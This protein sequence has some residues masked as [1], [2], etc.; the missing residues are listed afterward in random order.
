M[1]RSA[2]RITLLLS[3]AFAIV[4]VAAVLWYTRR[5]SV[6][7]Y[8][9]AET[10]RRPA[11]DSAPRDIMWEPAEPL[12]P[13]INTLDHEYEPRICEHGAAMFFVRG[14]AGE[15]A[16]IYYCL[17]TSAGWGEPAAL[18]AINTDA[19]ELGPEPSPDGLTLYFYSDRD[20]GAGGY[21]LWVTRNEDGVWREPVNLGPHVN[22]SF[23]EY[24][25]ALTPDESQ[26]YFSSNRPQPADAAPPDPDAWPATVR[27][28]LYQ[29]D[30]DLY[31]S[32]LTDRGVGNA[33]LVAGLNSEFNEGSPAISPVG[34]F[35]Y[36][37]SDRPGGEGGFDIYRSRRL[38]G[39]HLEAENLGPS[40]NTAANEL[41]PAVG[42]GGFELHFSSDRLREDDVAEI[43]G[44]YDLYSARSREVFMEYET[45]RAKIDW[46]ALAPY[47]PWALLAL[48]LLLLLLL[49]RRLELASRFATLS[50]LARCLL[51]SVLLHALAMMLFG[52]WTVSSALSDW[53][54]RGGGVRVA[55]VSPSVGDDLSVQVRGGLSE[56]EVEPV[57]ETVAQTA[58]IPAPEPIETQRRDLELEPTWIETEDLPSRIEHTADAPEP[59][60][61]Q[62]WTPSIVEAEPVSE[63]APMNLKLPE[64][65]LAQAEP[66]TQLQAQIATQEMT[67]ERAAESPQ[68]MQIRPADV[69][70]L[71]M[72]VDD[73]IDPAAAASMVEQVLPEDAPAPEHASPGLLSTATSPE[74]TATPAPNAPDLPLMPEAPTERV[75]ETEHMVRAAPSQHSKIQT[76]DLGAREPAVEPLVHIAPARRTDS[77]VAESMA[78][79][80][81]AATDAPV[82]AEGFVG[83]S[84]DHQIADPGMIALSLDA[85]PESRVNDD[86]ERQATIDVLTEAPSRRAL[87][88]PV[89]AR[90]PVDPAINTTV[91]TAQLI[92]EEV[93]VIELSITESETAAKAEAR[94]VN[95]P[96]GI[97]EPMPVELALPSMSEE[98]T[99]VVAE[100]AQDSEVREMAA[101]ERATAVNPS[102]PVAPT[103]RMDPS[104]EPVNAL[105]PLN[106]VVPLIETEAVDADVE[107]A[108]QDTGFEPLPAV[109]TPHPLDLALPTLEEDQTEAVVETADD[110]EVRDARR[111]ERVSVENPMAPDVPMRMVDPAPRRIDET[112]GV[113][114][115][116]PLIPIDLPETSS[117]PIEFEETPAELALLP[118]E[119]DLELPSQVEPPPEEEE[120]PAEIAGLIRGSVR[121]AV[122]GG[123]LAGATVRLDLADS[124]PVLATTDEQGNYALSAPDVPDFVALSASLE[125][126]TPQT[127]NVSAEELARQIVRRDFVLT[128]ERSNLIAIEADPRVHHLGD[129][130]FDGRINSQ[131]QKRSEGRRYR[132]EFEVTEAQLALAEGDAVLTLMAKGTQRD[133]QVRINGRRLE[134]SLNDSPSDGSFGEYESSFPVLRLNAGTNTIEVRSAWADRGRTDLDDFEF[135]NIQIELP[136]P[137]VAASDPYPQRADE[138]RRSMLERHGGSEETEQ[139]VALALEWLARHQSADGRWD[140]DGFDQDGGAS[141]GLATMDLDVGTTA[142]ALLCYLASD[143]HHLNEGPYQEVVASGI[144]WL[145]NQQE[146]TGSLMGEESMYSHGAATL[147]LAEALGMTGDL[148]LQRPVASAVRFIVRNR[149]R[150]VGGWSHAPGKPGDSAC[151]GW[152]VMAMDAAARAGVDVPAEGFEEALDW[153]DL[154]DDRAHRGL[155]AYQPGMAPT[156][157]TTAETLFVRQLLGVAYEGD[158]AARSVRWILGHRPSWEDN[159]DTYA[160]YFATLALHQ[161][162]GEAWSQWNE[163]VTSEIL[164][165]QVQLG[166][167]AGS[168]PVGDQWSTLCGRIYQ[169]A[170]CTLTL[171]VYYRYPV[172]ARDR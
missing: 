132:V 143:H 47:L 86:D 114:E 126:Y 127:V 83:P 157:A 81:E 74:P 171:E 145:L 104:L 155:Y 50:L 48:L 20:G 108:R 96:M 137:F 12:D 147:A 153:L 160:W 124:D 2:L 36:F 97:E 51:I 60:T 89:A 62:E 63:V 39:G 82:P 31:V 144:E 136:T 94:F 120:H 88:S 152:Q 55:V 139:A 100:A 154:I 46:R 16:D 68:P 9:D 103:R 34:D 107:T 54:D 17:R 123:P 133:N 43:A 33:E 119:L 115:P 21:D 162:Q 146:E 125:D 38:R 22:T 148:R 40:I 26:L 129:D 69:A 142:L 61:R 105:S 84:A 172:Q 42:L 158:D 57:I 159:P 29:R 25:P 141:A 85:L 59:E 169:T 67:A 13:G 79:R 99:Q 111:S 32:A 140:S 112:A 30:Y 109:Q 102:A 77:T 167:G 134:P 15:N 53:A 1:S 131:F 11:A 64:A 121:D 164:R 4:A 128:P 28:D 110:A 56:I 37:S 5:Q 70:I 93:P 14:K 116:L 161:H 75:A 118:L 168:W 117:L 122:T 135:V 163:M 3:A 8:T 66:E 73:S 78:R 138:Y 80:S 52:L 166:P 95:P 58:M 7:Y 76:S 49:L 106:D 44:D 27:E 113:A 18:D 87:V 65:A 151:L 98:R 41:D 149:D 72:P 130:V 35:I 71:P 24:G 165:R 150:D 6:G 23:N 170:M 19:E 10:I 101:S 45:F 92:P 90:P 156:P 91:T